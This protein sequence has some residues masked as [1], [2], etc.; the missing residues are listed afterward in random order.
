MIIPEFR[1]INETVDRKT[2]IEIS[3][4]ITEI[5]FRILEGFLQ[6]SQSFHEFHQKYSLEFFFSEIHLGILSRI[7]SSFFQEYLQESL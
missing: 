1:I 5:P 2:I 4:E 7:P 6:F 3:I